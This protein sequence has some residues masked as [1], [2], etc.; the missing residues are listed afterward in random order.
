MREKGKGELGEGY[1]GRETGTGGGLGKET[2][3]GGGLGER[4]GREVDWGRVIWV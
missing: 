4:G 1:W 3:T 2:G